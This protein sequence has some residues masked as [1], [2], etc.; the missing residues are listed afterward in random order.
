M[1]YVKTVSGC[2]CEQELIARGFDALL[3]KQIYQLIRLFNNRASAVKSNCSVLFHSLIGTVTL[4][5][6]RTDSFMSLV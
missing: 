1:L 6:K 5:G 3:N 2:G 4:T